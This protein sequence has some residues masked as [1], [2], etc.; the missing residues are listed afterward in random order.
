MLAVDEKNLPLRDA[1]GNLIFRPG[2]HGSLLTNLQNLDADFIFIKNI[3]NIVPEKL[4]KKI[5]PYK[6]ML[7]GLA[8]RIQQE[9]FA[10]FTSDGK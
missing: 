9:I 3:D 1:E 10:H 6:K 7:G 5:L 8:L 2:G 4:L